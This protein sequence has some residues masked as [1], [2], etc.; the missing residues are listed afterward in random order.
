MSEI[1]RVL[2]CN[3]CGTVLQDRDI[4][5]PGYVPE[6]IYKNEDDRVIYCEDCYRKLQ[7]NVEKESLSID[8]NILKVLDDAV[9][10]DALICYVVDLFA[11]NGYIASELA[12]KIKNNNIL[13]VGNKRDLLE[14]GVDD[15]TFIRYL[16][17]RFDDYG[18]EP[19]DIVLVSATKNYNISD[20]MNKI[21]DLR[22]RHDVYLIG[23]STSGKSAIIDALLAIYSNNSSRTIK[24]EEYP[25]TNLRI[26]SIPFDNSSTLYEVPGFI[27][28]N[29]LVYLLEKNILK[30]IVPKKTIKAERRTL[31][32]ETAIM[33]GGLA[34]ISLI[35][36]KSID[37]KVYMSK[38]IEL[39]RVMSGSIMKY[40]IDNLKKQSVK[41]VSSR[42]QDFK[43]FDL[44]DIKLDNDNELYDIA[45]RGLGRISIKAN[46]QTIRVLI[47][48]GVSLAVH[49]ARIR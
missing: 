25:N 13:V 4:T 47:P 40:F 28:K 3:N 2:R 26:L 11:F 14:V 33:F 9:A 12:K 30:F 37:I 16:K 48:R 43:D 31:S 21:D 8:K 19:A 34:F 41:P 44:F 23:S 17:E 1:H 36:G 22:K 20:L 46:G 7:I 6:S 35:D 18:I 24:S 15:E 5:S 39:K 49:K 32:K 29:S 38:D 42:F 45:I 10:S 27:N